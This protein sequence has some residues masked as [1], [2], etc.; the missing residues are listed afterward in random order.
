MGEQ[1]AAGPTSVAS[2]QPSGCLPADLLKEEDL[3]AAGKERDATPSQQKQRP[4]HPRIHAA[5]D[6]VERKQC[7]CPPSLMRTHIPSLGFPKSLEASEF[8]TSLLLGKNYG[9]IIFV[10][11]FHFREKNTHFVPP[12]PS[13][14]A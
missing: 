1:S 2:A 14:D 6:L 5:S 13:V 9:Q 8:I 3:N 12:A 11:A 10:I 7:L 4:R